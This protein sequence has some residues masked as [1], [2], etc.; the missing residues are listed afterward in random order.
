[1]TTRS[2]QCK[3]AI[4]TKSKDTDEDYEDPESADPGQCV[5]FSGDMLCMIPNMGVSGCVQKASQRENRVTYSISP[6]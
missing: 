5:G 4:F 6:V 2:Y 3:K 1:M